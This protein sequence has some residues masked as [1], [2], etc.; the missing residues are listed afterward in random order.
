MLAIHDREALLRFVSEFMARVRASRP[1]AVLRSFGTPVHTMILQTLGGLP[2]R[3]FQTG[4]LPDAEPLSGERMRETYTKRVIACPSCMTPCGM[5]T[6][7]DDGPY[8]SVTTLG[9]EFQCIAT[10]GSNLGH[11]RLDAVIAMDRL[12]DELGI[13]QTSTGNVIAF[14]M[15]CAERGLLTRSDLDGLD[16]RFGNHE[17]AVAL[18]GR[19]ARREGIG[20]LLAD[21]VKRAAEKIGGGAEEFACHV[22]GM[23]MTGFEPRALKSQAIGFAVSNRGPIPNEVR[24]LAEF[25]NAQDWSGTEGLGRVAKDL[26]DWTAIANCLVWCLSAERVLDFKPLPEMAAMVDAVTGNGIDEAGL[27]RVGERVQTLERLINVREGL[28]RNADQLP[29]RI[30]REALPPGMKKG[31]RVPS[32]VLDGWL[33]EYYDARG[34][35]RSGRPRPETIERLGLRAVLETP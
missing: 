29:D 13:G 34:W 25:F 32:T 12:T 16:L 23:E 19:I 4:V 33:D 35:D 5:V 9:P 17:A 31:S 28:A 2:T 3:N 21:G 8:A 26:S 6:A 11:A 7:V 18:I 1:A 22:K 14:A 30:V 20:D 15:E 10:L 24:P 27:V